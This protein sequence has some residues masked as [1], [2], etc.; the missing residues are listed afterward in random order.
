MEELDVVVIGA[1][2]VGL[3]VGRALAQAGREVVV[4]EK[5]RTIGSGVSARN[6]EVIHAGLYYPTGSLKAELCVR[7][8]ALLYELCA[9]HGVAVNMCGKLVVA[10]DD[11]QL[12]ALHALQARAQANGVPIEWLTRTQAQ[13]MEPALACLAALHSPTT[14][15]VDSHGLMLAMQGDLERAG[16]CVALDSAVVAGRV[17]ADGIELT[18]HSPGAEPTRLL[19]CTV[20]NAAALHATAVAQAIQGLSPRHIPQA[21]FA[22][23]SY[24]TLDGHAPFSRLLYPAPQDAWLG[25]HLTLDLGGQAKFGP[26]LEWLNVAEPDGIDYAVDPARA[27]SFYAEVRRYWPDLPDGALVPGYSGVRPKIYGPGQSAPDFRI[28]GPAVHGVP[29]LVNLFGIESPGLT[30]SLAIGE[31]VAR[32]LGHE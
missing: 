25:V 23:G 13:A 9:S 26:D 24:Y 19:A 11:A 22:K 6:S 20:V 16:G 17:Q 3:A 28:D 2:V 21:H 5:E 1:G 31:H 14:G 30:S 7:G 8:K 18:V 29:G 27:E 15:I 4:L 32:L 12:H 10:T